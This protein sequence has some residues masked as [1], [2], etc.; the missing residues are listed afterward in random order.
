MRGVMSKVNENLFLFVLLAYGIALFFLQ[1]SQGAFGF[2]L[3][4]FGTSDLIFTILWVAG[5]IVAVFRK[6]HYAL[7]YLAFLFISMGMAITSHTFF[8][9]SL[10][11]RIER[12]PWIP[13][14]TFLLL[15]FALFY[16]KVSSKI[17]ALQF[18]SFIVLFS[19]LA[20]Y[21]LNRLYNVH[22]W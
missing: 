17:Y 6:K 5:C 7:N 20:T 15:V 14:L 3:W 11:A 13:L 19:L 21:Q 10:F 1:L 9:S 2:F 4:T 18:T 22:G 8:V 12:N 16:L